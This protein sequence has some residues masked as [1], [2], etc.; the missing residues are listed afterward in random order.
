[1]R[2]QL[3]FL[4]CLAAKG[5]SLR[6]MV[7]DSGA[8]DGHYIG[9][10]TIGNVINAPTLQ[11]QPTCINGSLD[12]AT[13]SKDCSD[14]EA[15]IQNVKPTYCARVDYTNST[16]GMEVIRTCVP[17]GINGTICGTNNGVQVCAFVTTCST[18]NC[19]NNPYTGV[20]PYAS[21]NTGSGTGT[22]SGNGGTSIVGHVLLT[23]IGLFITLRLYH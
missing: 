3:F 12:S 11:N 16:G 9:L 8:F 4:L 18:N 14:V 13:F 21:T 2:I 23:V 1:M 19:N 17:A 5:W 10:Q 22:G 20:N 15:Q 6:C 7:C